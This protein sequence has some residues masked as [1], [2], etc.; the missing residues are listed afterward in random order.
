MSEKK[1]R[2]ALYARVSA[3]G[4]QSVRAQLEALRE[5]A[6]RRGWVVS[7]EVAEVRSGAKVRPKRE[8]LAPSTPLLS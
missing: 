6:H 3:A 4:Q 8:G 7:L 5:Y 2:V 1:I